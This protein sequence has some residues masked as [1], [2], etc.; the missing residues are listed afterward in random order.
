MPAS[1]SGIDPPARR[2]GGREGDDLVAGARRRPRR[3]LRA[4]RGCSCS[5][6]SARA[7]AARRRRRSS[8]AVGEV[9]E[10]GAEAAGVGRARLDPGRHERARD[11]EADAAA[12]V[13]GRPQRH[14]QRR[15]G[16]RRGSS[17]R[18]TTRAALGRDDRLRPR[19][20]RGRRS[21][22]V[23][24]SLP[25]GALDPLVGDRLPRPGVVRIEAARRGS[26][27]RSARR[28][29]R[30]R[31][32]PGRWRRACRRASTVPVGEHVLGVDGLAAARELAARRARRRRSRA[33]GRAAA[34]RRGRR[35]SGRCG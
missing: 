10:V 5:R 20:E 9:E 2:R 27:S 24:A 3:A 30:G 21:A 33:A 14:R 28:P 32:R 8:R 25:A 15:L 19:E 18:P 26:G 34:R 13:R 22:S 12:P 4:S 23:T 29:G 17:R 31:R 11:R 35:R 16:R 1:A 6:P 7:R